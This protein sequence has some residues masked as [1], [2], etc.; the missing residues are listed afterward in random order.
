MGALGIILFILFLVLLSIPVY[1]YNRNKHIFNKEQIDEYIRKQIVQ[2]Q[3]K[4]TIT[5]QS[6]KTDEKL[7]ENELNELF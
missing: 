2:E 5:F 3:K 4:H 1:Y 6:L 7:T